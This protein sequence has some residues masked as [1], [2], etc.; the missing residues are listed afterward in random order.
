MEDGRERSRQYGDL[1]YRAGECV[2]LDVVGTLVY[3]LLPFFVVYLKHS[4]M[5]VVV[6]NPMDGK[7]GHYPQRWRWGLRVREP[8]ASTTG[9]QNRQRE[10]FQQKQCVHLTRSA[11]LLLTCSGI[12]TA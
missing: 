4:E 3:Y 5:D 12:G 9:L 7:T 8:V 10:T 6:R 11:R 1:L 2:P